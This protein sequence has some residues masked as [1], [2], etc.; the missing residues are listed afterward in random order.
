M[1]KYSTN[2][3]EKDFPTD[4]ACLE[5]LKQNRWPDGI[6]C[7]KCGKVTNHYRITG[8]PCYSCESC[9]S[10][11]YPMAGT[12]FEDTK[13]DHLK[14]WFKAIAYMS[15]TRCGVSSRQLSRDLGVTVKTGYRM[16]KQIRSILNED[17]KPLSNEVEMDETYIGG[18][19]ANM[20]SSKR[21]KLS[22]RGTVGKIP[23][24][25]AV[26]RKGKIV[27]ATVP[28]VDHVTLLPHIKEHVL[29]TAM[30]CTDEAGGYYHL[31]D[32]GYNHKII[33]HNEKVYAIGN[34]HTNTIEGFWSQLK[35]SIDGTYH[36]VTAEHLQEYID[37][38]SFRYNHRKD[39]KPMFI[40]MLNQ[41]VQHA[42]EKASV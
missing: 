12:I 9:G 41:V 35:R 39:E 40:S 42:S 13:F 28:N 20:H 27:A 30:V 10:H 14:L 3:F 36:H 33:R 18:I 16:W 2:D 17:I 21:K 22:G 32:D 34:V 29:P 4:D 26:E 1:K 24:W 38:Y 15:V 11:I 19:A 31:K 8:R 25:G 7:E 37:E 23:V 5:W 6:H